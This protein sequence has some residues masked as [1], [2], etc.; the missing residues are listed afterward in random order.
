VSAIEIPILHLSLPWET[1]RLFADALGAYGLFWMVGLLASLR[2]HPHVIN[3]AGLR[4]RN[5]PSVDITLPW[6]AIAAIRTRNR[7]MPTRR[8]IQFDQTES[9]LVV[10]IVILSETNVDVTLRHPTTVPLP[11]GMSEPVTEL[12][13]YADDPDAL[14][15]R[16]RARLTADV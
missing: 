14:A 13:L 1:A 15:A 16:A 6:D 7:P 10:H 11:K 8:A 2:V 3:D 9:G 12:R 5:G 4:V